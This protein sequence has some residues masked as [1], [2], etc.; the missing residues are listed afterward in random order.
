MVSKSAYSIS[1]LLRSFF[2]V[3]YTHYSFLLL[4]LSFLL[5]SVSAYFPS[6]PLILLLLLFIALLFLPMIIQL[7]SLT[8]F[9]LQILF[10]FRI[11]GIFNTVKQLSV[12]SALIIELIKFGSKYK[13]VMWLYTN[14]K[15]IAWGLVNTLEYFS[16]SILF[17]QKTFINHANNIYLYL[18]NNKLIILQNL[19]ISRYL[20]LIAL[21]LVTHVYMHLHMII[22]NNEKDLLH[23]WT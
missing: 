23:F 22:C 13:L 19:N 15:T 17:W 2:F 21:H 12:L 16:L 1:P 9:F 6:P 10:L 20:N 18:Y 8:L 4:L 11:Q 5:L 14:Y 7:L 3:C